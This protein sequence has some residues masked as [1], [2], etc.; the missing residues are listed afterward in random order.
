MTIAFTTSLL[1]LNPDNSVQFFHMRMFLLLDLVYKIA[2]DNDRIEMTFLTN[3][4]SNESGRWLV[5]K[6]VDGGSAMGP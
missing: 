4:G 2:A 3:Q 6:R 1:R 5:G